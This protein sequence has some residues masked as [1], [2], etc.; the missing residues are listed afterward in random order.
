MKK[1]F[2]ILNIIGI[3]IIIHISFILPEEPFKIIHSLSIHSID[4]PVWL[5]ISII[6]SFLYTIILWLIYSIAFKI[7]K[8]I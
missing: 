4:K 5:C 2:L 7:N 1:I 8:R 3:I 6:L